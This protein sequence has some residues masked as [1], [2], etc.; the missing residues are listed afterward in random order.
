MIR[1]IFISHSLLVG[2][3][4]AFCACSGEYQPARE[5]HEDTDSVPVADSSATNAADSII[6]GTAMTDEVMIQQMQSAPLQVR[7]LVR[8]NL[9]DGCTRL[10]SAKVERNENM[11][12]IR[13]D[14]RR[15]KNAVCTQALVPYEKIIPLDVS[16][17]QNR[18]INVNVNGTIKTVNLLKQVE[19]DKKE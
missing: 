1:K 14:T 15:P 7:V 11:F 5:I 2:M 3:A 4:F 19:E 6:I 8:G 17:V 18:Q 16:E 12:N 9:P 13:L 10:D